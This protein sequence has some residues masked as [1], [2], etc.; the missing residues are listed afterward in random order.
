MGGDAQVDAALTSIA[1]AVA[2]TIGADPSGTWCTYARIDRMSLGEHPA[3]GGGGVVFV[4]VWMRSRGAESDR[5]AL[6]AVTMSTAEGFG[7]PHEDVWA[8]LRT[9]EPGRVIAG[10]GFVEG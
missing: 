6:M 5:E 2:A 8:T 1:R 3:D 4:D 7:V 9:V 10:G